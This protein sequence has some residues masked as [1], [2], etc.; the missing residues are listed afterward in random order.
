MFQTIFD[1]LTSSL[2]VCCYGSRKIRRKQVCRRK[3]RLGKFRLIG[4][5]AILHPQYLTPTL[6]TPFYC[7]L[8]CTFTYQACPFGVHCLLPIRRNFLRQKFLRRVFL[9]QTCLRRIFRTRA[10]IKYSICKN[11]LGWFSK[12]KLLFDIFLKLL[13]HF[14][15]NELRHNIF[16][17]SAPFTP[18]STQ[19]LFSLITSLRVTIVWGRPPMHP[20]CH[21]IFRNYVT[22]KWEAPMRNATGM[23]Q[24]Q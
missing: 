13:I 4:E 8:P 1:F 20:T 6:Y 19:K 14:Q 23:F 2:R 18:F 24:R 16:S 15:I 21:V 10:V 12:P 22:I 9:R 3:T 11:Y 17:F 7:T 5:I